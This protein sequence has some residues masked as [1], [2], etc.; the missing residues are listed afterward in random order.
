M[1]V[2][3]YAYIYIY[4]YILLII[5]HNGVSHLKTVKFTNVTIFG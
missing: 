4:I 1:C 3:M 2:C 5:E